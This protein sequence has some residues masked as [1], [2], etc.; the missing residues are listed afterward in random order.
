L[1]MRPGQAGPREAEGEDDEFDEDMRDELREKRLELKKLKMEKELLRMEAEAERL[2]QELDRLRQPGLAPAGNSGS[3]VGSLVAN[4]VR[5]GVSP[6]QA[7]EFL[8]KLSP[9]ALAALSALASNNPYLPLFLYIASQG[10]GT[11]P[12]S[13]TV[14]DVVEI[15][16]AVHEWARDLAA[17]G[18]GRGEGDVLGAIK[19]LADSIKDLYTSQLLS[20][21]DEI[22]SAM[23][24]SKSPWESILEDDTKFR[25]FKELFGGGGQLPPDVVVKLEEMRQAHEREMKKLDLEL[26]KLRAELLESRRKAKQFSMALRRVGE[27][28][29]EGLREASSPYGLAEVRQATTLKCLKCGADIPGCYP[30]AAVTCPSCNATYLVQPKAGGQ[31]HGQAQAPQVAKAEQAG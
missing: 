3:A 21:L 22:K 17:A 12:Q 27:A 15:N 14:K 19:M 2:R 29:G 16:K 1:R 24:G 11:P 30:G 20:K 9:E 26:M 31:V 6:E 13:L 23:A 28:I 10:R 25:R 8:S 4:M 18:R 7:N 5:S